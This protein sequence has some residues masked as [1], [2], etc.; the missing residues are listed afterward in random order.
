MMV[1]KKTFIQVD[2]LVLLLRGKLTIFSDFVEV[3]MPL[4]T[5]LGFL[6]KG[7]RAIFRP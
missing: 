3:I 1:M 2:K 4:L 6:A 5:N 7:A